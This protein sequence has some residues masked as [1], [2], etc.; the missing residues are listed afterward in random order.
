MHGIFLLLSFIL[1]TYQ[2]SKWLDDNLAFLQNS[3]SPS[4][5]GRLL[6]FHPVVGRRRLSSSRFLTINSTS[7]RPSLKVK[8]L[9]FVHHVI[10]SASSVHRQCIISA[11]SVHH[12]CIIMVSSGPHQDIIGASSGHHQHII[13]KLS[14]VYH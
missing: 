4:S 3:A 11:S 7:I 14:L 5:R 8:N 10:L 1:Q 9:T 6:Y 13:S 2:C 12:Q